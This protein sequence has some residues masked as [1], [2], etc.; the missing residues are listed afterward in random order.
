MKL[1]PDQP[2][3]LPGKAKQRIRSLQAAAL[4]ES[5]KEKPKSPQ[6]RL[7]GL[8]GLVATRLAEHRKDNTPA[9]SCVSE[10]EQEGLRWLNEMS[11]IDPLAMSLEALLDALLLRRLL[12]AMQ[13]K[14][15]LLERENSPSSTQQAKQAWQLTVEHSQVWASLCDAKS[16]RKINTVLRKM[17]APEHTS[18]LSRGKVSQLEQ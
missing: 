15:E 6:A 5:A 3:R 2:L 17:V 11:Q 8:M 9:D 16:A 18:S 12:K 1:Q 4:I 7:A 13:A 14:I 10:A